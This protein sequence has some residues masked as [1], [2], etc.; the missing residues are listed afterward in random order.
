[1][2]FFIHLKLY[3]FIHQTTQVPAFGHY[4][5]LLVMYSTQ[6]KEKTKAMKNFNL[7]NDAVLFLC[8]IL[9]T[10]SSTL[11]YSTIFLGKEENAYTYIYRHIKICE[12][13]VL[14]FHLVYK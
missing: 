13:Y 10:S 11:N 2:F 3:Y 6:L 1:M 8:S 4:I 5:P 12:L 9:D 14:A 7:D